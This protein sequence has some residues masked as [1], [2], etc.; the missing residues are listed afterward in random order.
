MSLSQSSRQLSE[1]GEWVSLEELARRRSINPASAARLARRKHWR[2]QP[3]NDGQ[4]RVLIPSEAGRPRDNLMDAVS[5]LRLAGEAYKAA[6][7]AFRGQLSAVEAR[8]ERAERRAEKAEGALEALRREIEAEQGRG[9]WRRALA[10]W[11]GR[12]MGMTD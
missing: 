6:E 7:D 1:E 4:V 3:G 8:A 11:R 10:A 2:T 9:R 12:P 5:A